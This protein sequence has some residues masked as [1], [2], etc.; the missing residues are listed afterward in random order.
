LVCRVSPEH[1]RSESPAE[2]GVRFGLVTIR[3]NDPLLVI[4]TPLA[5][6]AFITTLNAG[7][8]AVDQTP[9]TGTGIDAVKLD[10]R[11]AVGGTTTFLGNLTYGGTASDTGA[12]Y[13]S[14]FNGSV[15]D[16]LRPGSYD[17][18]VSGRRNWNRRFF[19]YHPGNAWADE[20]KLRRGIH[21]R[22][23]KCLSRAGVWADWPRCKRGWRWSELCRSAVTWQCD[24]WAHVNFGSEACEHDIQRR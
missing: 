12:L 13:G 22:L 16:R 24:G 6:A 4:D 1:P 5:N 3:D 18:I 21:N 15:Y 7:G 17:L 20:P 23:S 2:A 8:W 10:A 19:R 9:D 11:P 14:R